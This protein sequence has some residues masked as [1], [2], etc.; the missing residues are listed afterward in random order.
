VTA[1]IS[2]APAARAGTDPDRYKWIALS[3]TTLAVLLATLDASITLIAMPDIFRGIHLDPLVPSNSFY[4]LWMILGYLVVTSVLI[5]SLGRLGDMFG[6]VRIYNLG[7]V[8]YTVASLL[9]TIDWMT[10]RAGATYLIVFRI[11]QGVGGACLLANAAAIITDAFPANQ[12]G[13]ALGINNI[14]GVSGMFVGLILGGLLAPVDWRLVFLISVP[15]GLFGTVWAYLKLEER[16]TPRRAPIDWLGNVTFALGLVLLMVAVTYGIRPAGGHSTG[17]A[18]ARVLG[19]LAGSIVSLAL[20]ARVERRVANPMFRL[21]LFKIRAFTFGTLSTFLSAVARG[22]LMFMLI[23]WLQGIWLPEHGYSFTSTPLWAGIYMVP[24]ILGMLVA[25]PTSG[26]LSDRFGARGFATGGMVGAALSFFLLTLLPT[27]FPYPLFALI[28]LL[29][30]VSMGMFASPNRAAVMNS[31]PPGDRGA[32]GGMNQT[33]QNSAQ[34]LSIGIFFTLM[35]IGLASSLPHTLSSGLHAH[36]VPVATAHTIGALPPVSILF[37]AFLG[38]NPIQHLVGP[39]VLGMLS[40]HNQAVLTG[41]TFFPHLISAPFRSGLHAA[42][43]FAIVAC[44][45]AAAASFMRGERYEHIEP[46]T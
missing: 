9:L 7:F 37:A 17:W 46:A 33:F 21:P 32:G 26:Y 35:I 14:V 20:F 3:N 8:I 36:G 45:I 23:I 41:P 10:G 22:G 12:R 34:V 19:L 42:F 13:M 24:L 2:T 25:G 28:L 43:A 38:Y 15:V 39:H 27:D 16:S 40:A 31:L 5:V 29:N 44:L 1:A 11:L 4:L 18:S 30:G 6:R